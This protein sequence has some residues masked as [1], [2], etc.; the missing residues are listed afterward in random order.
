MVAMTY[1]GLDADNAP[2]QFPFENPNAPLVEVVFLQTYT[3]TTGNQFQQALSTPYAPNQEVL[4]GCSST[5]DSG[6]STF[7]GPNEAAALIARG[8]ARAV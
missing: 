5:Y 7:V 6:S 1:V 4:V 8:I 3:R 2:V